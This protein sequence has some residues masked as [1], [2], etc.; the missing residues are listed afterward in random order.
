VERVCPI[1]KPA[2]CK[3]PQRTDDACHDEKR[4]AEGKSQDMY[5]DQGEQEYSQGQQGISAEG[6]AGQ[7][8]TEYACAAEQE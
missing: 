1:R 4:P 7:P 6:D 3:N 2:V 5:D 8:V